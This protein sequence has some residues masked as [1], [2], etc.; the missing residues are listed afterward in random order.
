MA[1]PQSVP[2]LTALFERLGARD[3]E[4]WASSQIDSHIPQ[5]HR[6]LFLR[7]CW[8]H[9]MGENSI[10]WIDSHIQLSLIHI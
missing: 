1:I 7:Q 4:S 2:E 5:L 6:Y 10:G 9:V 3:P 8:Q